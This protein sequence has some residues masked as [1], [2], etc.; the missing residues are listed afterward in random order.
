M[1]RN[2]LFCC[3]IVFVSIGCASKNFHNDAVNSQAI[4]VPVEVSTG[5]AFIVHGVQSRVDVKVASSLRG[6]KKLEKEI[7]FYDISC[8]PMSCV[9]KWLE[10]NGCAKNEAGLIGFSPRYTMWTSFSNTLEVKQL[11][12][13][14]I[15][16]VVF[17]AVGHKSPA[18]ITLNFFDESA[19]PY[20]KR[21]KSFDAIGFVDA[22]KF[23]SDSPVIDQVAISGDRLKQL[24]C[25]LFLPGI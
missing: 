6:D 4:S 25:P 2:L 10:L 9:L 19:P 8:T 17:Q 5:N 15:E 20:L 23:L 11:S 24:D 14:V 13:T 21:L 12:D 16:I 7:Y 1:N 22:K 3:A 18:K